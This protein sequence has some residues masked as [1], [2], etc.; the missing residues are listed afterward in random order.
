MADL[1]WSRGYGEI[2]PV[3]NESGDIIGFADTR[4]RTPEDVISNGQSSLYSG[5]TVYGYN[6][7]GGSVWVD[8][9][10]DIPTWVELNKDTGDID[11]YAPDVVV[12]SE[13]YK[14]KVEP[15]LTNLSQAYKS[16]PDYKM[17]NPLD[18]KDE[19]KDYTVE[20][21]VQKIQDGINLN[22]MSLGN[23]YRS[24]DYV[25]SQLGSAAADRY[26][27]RRH[28]I[29]SANGAS[30]E[31]DDLLSI[32]KT[33]S[34]NLRWK[35]F[36]KEAESFKDDTITVK[37]FQ[38]KYYHTDAGR[39]IFGYDSPDE[40]KKWVRQHLEAMNKRGAENLS[41]EEFDEYLRLQAF[42]SYLSGNEPKKDVING[43][44]ENIFGAA[45]GIARG[46]A[47]F[48]SGLASLA[49][50]I[51][52]AVF[53][54]GNAEPGSE[55][56][57]NF[58]NPVSHT[59]T[60]ISNIGTNLV[61]GATGNQLIGYDNMLA[62]DH[63]S[64]ELRALYDSRAQFYVDTNR[65]ASV[66]F[67]LGYTGSQIA[68]NVAAGKA[69]TGLTL[70][71]ASR[72]LAIHNYDKVMNAA[73]LND[74]IVQQMLR[75][76]WMTGIG[77]AAGA[78]TTSTAMAAST[79]GTLSSMT[80]REAV[81]QF[82]TGSTN[83]TMYQLISGLSK[84][85]PNDV[86]NMSRVMVDIMAEEKNAVGLA[87]ALKQVAPAMVSNLKADTLAWSVG[88]LV[89]QTVLDASLQNPTAMR[90][91]IE[92][93]GTDEERNYLFQQAAWNAAGYGAGLLLGKMMTAFPKS[94]TGKAANEAATRKLW[95]FE[96]WVS[97]KRDAV[98]EAMFGKDWMKNIK[99][100]GKKQV[101]HYKYVL[102]KAGEAIA[103]SGGDVSK[104]INSVKVGSDVE[105]AVRNMR[106]VQVA[107][108]QKEAG[109][110]VKVNE[111]ISDAH[112]EMKSTVT[113]LDN[114][115]AELTKQ[116]TDAGL[117]SNYE[118][119]IG[120]ADATAGWPREVNNYIGNLIEKRILDNKLAKVG[121]K[122]M[123]T[124]E[125]VKLLT[126]AKFTPEQRRAYP[127]LVEAVETAENSLPENIT[128]YIKNT[129][130]P[131]LYGAATAIRA[132]RMSP[133][134]SLDIEDEIM[135]YISTGMWGDDGS[136]FAPMIRITEAQ[137][138]HANEMAGMASTTK[139]GFIKNRS[140]D[141]E[142]IQ[143]GSQA[144]FV[145]PT[146]AL[147]KYLLQTAADEINQTSLRAMLNIP[148][149]KS[150]VRFDGSK[151]GAARTYDKLSP[152][153]EK[154]VDTGVGGVK[155]VF[156]SSDIADLVLNDYETRTA[157]QK[158]E[159][160]K[161]RSIKE[162]SKLEDSSSLKVTAVGRSYALQSMS[163]DNVENVLDDAFAKRV[164][165]GTYLNDY[166]KIAT[167]EDAMTDADTWDKFIL[168]SPIGVRRAIKRSVLRYSNFIGTRI[169]EVEF[170]DAF[171]DTALD[172]MNGKDALAY[173]AEKNSTILSEIDE[174]N[175]LSW[176]IAKDIASGTKDGFGSEEPVYK[177][178]Y[179][180]GKQQKIHPDIEDAEGYI[181]E[182]ATA[183][184]YSKLTPRQRADIYDAM[185]KSQYMRDGYEFP[186]LEDEFNIS[187]DQARLIDQDA[188]TADT[189]IPEEIKTVV[190]SINS[191]DNPYLSA[192]ITDKALEYEAFL[193][194]SE[195]NPDVITDVNRAMIKADKDTYKDS[196][197]I[198]KIAKNQRAAELMLTA[199]TRLNEASRT[200]NMPTINSRMEFI[201]TID[202]AIDGVMKAILDDDNAVKALD[203]IMVGQDVD[204]DT[205]REY[206]MMVFIKKHSKD[207]K[208]AAED[209]F[210]Y[211]KFKNA[212]GKMAGTN[213]AKIQNQMVKEI[214]NRITERLN[215]ARNAFTAAGGEAVDGDKVLKEIHDLMDDIEKAGHEANIVA[216]RQNGEELLVETD[217]IVANL[218]NYHVIDTTSSVE[219]MLSNPVVK[220]MNRIARF[221]QT[222]GS[223]KS[224]LKNQPSRDTL[225]SFYG[226]GAVPVYDGMK[227]VSKELA[228]NYAEAIT[229]QYKQ[230]YPSDYEFIEKNLKP[231]ENIVDKVIE[232]I[233][234]QGT[235]TS[236]ALTETAYYKEPFPE[237]GNS[238][239]EPLNKTKKALGKTIEK[240][241]KVVETPNQ[242]RE[243][244]LR[245]LNFSKGLRDGIRAGMSL[246]DAINMAKFFRD[247]GTTN[248]RHQ[249]YHLRALAGTVN[250][251]GAGING[252][253]SFW[254][255]YSL[256]PVG[257]TTRIFG[258]LVIPIIVGIGMSL[259]SEENRKRY[260]DLKEYEK[261][262]QF[263]FV[264]NGEVV[265]IPIP[266]EFS[267][268]INPIRH[269]V[270]SLYG[271]NK[272]AFWELMMTD[273]LNIG[274]IEFGDLMDIDRNEFSG[275]PTIL[276][277]MGS[278]GIGL[279][280]QTAP[281]VVKTLFS[282]ATG[283][284]T[285]TGQPIDTS[286]YSFDEDGNRIL[287]GGTQ[288]EF[289]LKLG[290]A[291]GWSPSVIAWTTKNLIG[292]VGRDILDAVASGDISTPI[293]NSLGDLSLTASDY[294]RTASD[295]NRE[296]SDL[297]RQKESKY[298]PEYND[299]TDQINRENDPEKK[300]KLKNKR[301]DAIQPFFNQVQNMVKTLNNKYPGMYDR[302]RF[303]SV[304][305]L[306]NFDSGVA[307]GTDAAA[308][309]RDLENFYQNR[310]QAYQWM[311]DLGISGSDSGSILGHLE[312][313]KEGNVVVKINSPL[314]IL[315][316]QSMFYGAK[317][318]HVANIQ[319]ILESGTDSYK[320]QLTTVKNQISAI[321][322]RGNLSQSDYDEIDDI[323]IEWDKKVIAA[324]APYVQQYTPEAAINNEEVLKYIGEYLY[325]PD[326]FK[327]DKR[328]YSVSN[329]SL[330][331]L[332]NAE[333]AFKENFIKYAFGINDRR[334]D[335]SWNFSNRKTLGAQ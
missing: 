95:Q 189:E 177:M 245:N 239:W 324:L 196:E 158:A 59:V 173:R 250:Y 282:F 205:A 216:L 37:D 252:Y 71:A 115:S 12:N 261:D 47:E 45:E 191:P 322:D 271:A 200:L 30:G 334:Y 52:N 243:V 50:G 277:R 291:T 222:T 171:R 99:N 144:D 279:I 299:Y 74:T 38:D 284:D 251:F 105:A 129:Y 16:N 90:K 123:P 21:I 199:T 88:D 267:A 236:P 8:R 28:A 257:V 159:T 182:E 232:S 137:K 181:E 255:L 295:W 226:T 131:S 288:S 275:D 40:M 217:P 325:V 46:T 127:R 124:G 4:G 76:D 61:L 65:E 234:A 304:V 238:M 212:I 272:H 286:Y 145:N 169:D 113:T 78:T 80:G 104:T 185:K 166:E 26:D 207:I 268:F 313:D 22:Q 51:W 162:L 151:T 70:G 233:F 67:M 91:L 301:K 64:D 62:T 293:K 194:A 280:D 133:K 66:Y 314:E 33:V 136:E 79:L 96:G 204:V 146:I 143:W 2:L 170:V 63:V 36:F 165:K 122:T 10:E 106:A 176:Q 253:T 187:K 100:P 308:K 178:L 48:T 68:A 117:G 327:K 278:L 164:A 87:A 3:E 109:L 219:K 179:K 274:P 264:M 266:Q 281:L 193:K 172:V 221:F 276:D 35:N 24:R 138:Q 56:Y 270:E 335:T 82:I 310:N 86:V 195:I 249:L 235:S 320:N 20:E 107:F 34:N 93:S 152:A 77:T 180:I 119:K 192:S 148:T 289:S 229:E 98:K 81:N 118:L 157:I 240:F 259:A 328:G 213:I 19:K 273:A 174:D 329:K 6:A 167:I 161:K 125:E 41:D 321:Y 17:P 18:S 292:T 206:T 247:N 183:I 108:D 142:K 283:I 237:R 287:V 120:Q 302:Y 285:Y 211:D 186:E 319:T 97:S 305:S 241:G 198:T 306:L 303:A 228:A 102:N 154:A 7:G 326:A 297:W 265:K 258:G 75:A 141:P 242:A 29:L 27:M 210:E 298:L 140:S 14:T 215:D 155:R 300:Q 218:S 214:D 202:N 39:D 260:K 315:S 332:G 92:G 44:V 31:D 54:L 9:P 89:M 225:N 227:F 69:L 13:L 149:I 135:G 163:S 296:I 58:A 73:L 263:V 312:R 188:K 49:D 55:A 294:S 168:N 5:K 156:D 150:S 208:E 134:I 139:T 309:A 103:K 153:L 262:N 25:K 317:D 316:A 72:L 114:V 248:F 209:V 112:P 231:G 175:D 110:R 330:N 307:S 244:Y 311:Q 60:G 160:Q 224:V 132:Y 254:R 101:A 94:A 128:S 11:V 147:H 318:I 203:A 290:K 121:I 223:P 184:D 23:F 256:D 84:I 32:P 269:A 331:Y 130:I 333:D 15:L 83:P 246:E 230:L 190:D 85:N 220:G 43:F 42:N 323:K 111:Y 116:L 57:K 201:N 197:L 1:K 126:D 53:F